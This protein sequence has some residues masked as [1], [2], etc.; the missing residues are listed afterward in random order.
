MINAIRTKYSTFELN[1]LK[2]SNDKFLSCLV[3]LTLFLSFALALACCCS[4]VLKNALLLDAVI[5][6]LFYSEKKKA[7]W[8]L[9]YT[10]FSSPSLVCARSLTSSKFERKG[11]KVRVACVLIL[12][13]FLF[14]VSAK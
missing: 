7:N 14:L 11:S 6:M 1:F 9:L 8:I 10:F 4:F 5:G 12:L 2:P 3:S 13:L